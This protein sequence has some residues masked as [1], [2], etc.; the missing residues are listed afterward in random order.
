MRRRIFAI[1]TDSAGCY[2]YRLHWP[3]THLNPDE[4]DVYW[5]APPDER[6]PGDVVVGQRLAGDNPAWLKMCADPG[7]LAVY[8]IDDDVVDVD[9][10]NTIPYAIFAPQRDGTIANIAAADVVTCSTPYLAAKIAARWNPRTVVLP[11]CIPSRYLIQAHQIG[12]PREHGLTIG[13]AGSPFHHQD[14]PAVP[15]A[16]ATFAAQHPGARFALHG[17]DYSQGQFTVAFSRPFTVF[18]QHVADLDFGIGLAPLARTEFNRSKSWAKLLEY[19]ARGIPAV[20]T[21]W[22][23]YPDWFD[24]LP[25]EAPG[26]LIDQP[27]EIIDALR[28]LCEDAPRARMA[29]A[30]YARAAACTTEKHL[31]RW[32]DVYRTQPEG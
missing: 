16:L 12:T 2:L 25:G 11:N 9:P 21:R 32:A 27:D 5:G 10:A 31:W 1:A 14:W 18:D 26:I 22:G 23:Q 8:E 30:A 15:E 24:L 19:G 6:Q 13:W 7:I 20:A 29:T 28:V 17:A 3:L 4:F